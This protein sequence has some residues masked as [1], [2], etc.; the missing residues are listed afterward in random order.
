MFSI[1]VFGFILLFDWMVYFLGCYLW[2]VLGLEGKFFEENF[3]RVISFFSLRI[4]RDGFRGGLLFLLGGW[5]LLIVVVVCEDGWNRVFVFLGNFVILKLVGIGFK[6]FFFVGLVRA[7]VK[8]FA[9]CCRRVMGR[10][11]VREGFKN[12]IEREWEY[13]FCFD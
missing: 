4:F 1:L 7:I 10:L 6:L 2:E 13:F 11:V 8:I 9:C 12:I 5:L 3:L